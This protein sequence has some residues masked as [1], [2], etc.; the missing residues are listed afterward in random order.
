MSQPVMPAVNIRRDFESAART[1]REASFPNPS[2]RP[3][4]VPTT[5]GPVEQAIATAAKRTSVDFDFL[6]AQAQVESAMNPRAKA[7]SSSAT[8]LYQFIESTWLGTMKRHGARF[9][10]GNVA[11]QINATASGGAHVPDAGQRKAILEMR[12]D[13]QIASL[14]AAGL[15]EDNRAKLLPVLGREPANNELYL[16]HFLGAGGASRFLTAMAQN[17][18]QSAAAIFPRPAS[19]NRPVFYDAGGT[20]RSL[21]GVM[22]FLSDRLDRAFADAP[23]QPAMQTEY[24]VASLAPQRP[25]TLVESAAMFAPARPPINPSGLPAPAIGRL[26]QNRPPMSD[27]LSATFGEVGGLASASPAAAKRIERAYNQLKAFGL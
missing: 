13:P 26:S 18:D 20:P 4:E 17:P 10:L 5:S 8:G 2:A 11:D 21:A 1:H 25:A 9:G 16:A 7:R 6:L 3:A 19:A 12:N 24:S 27:L 22:D 14:M 23:A 15:A